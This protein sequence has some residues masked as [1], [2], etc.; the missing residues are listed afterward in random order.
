MGCGITV[1]S[2]DCKL[3]RLTARVDT[4][5]AVQQSVEIA[6]GSGSVYAL[7]DTAAAVNLGTDDP[8]ITLGVAGT[9]LLFASAQLE[10]AAATITTQTAA[11]KLRRTNNTAADITGS[12]VAIDLPVVTT[13]T[14]TVG[15][16]QTPPV[17]YTTTEDDD[18][19]TIF[20]NL[21][22][23]AGAGAVNV[24]DANIVAVRLY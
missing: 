7:T 20:A 24:S 18:A 10:Y 17:L 14:H 9:Y 13:L 3:N 6:N 4:A 5:E 21:S 8:T 11:L 22:A 23:A 2:L 15:I 19:I 16:F 1:E 12:T